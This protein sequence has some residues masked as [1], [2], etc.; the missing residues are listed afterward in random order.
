MQSS[1][2][3]YSPAVA[4]T[5]EIHLARQYSVDNLVERCLP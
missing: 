3:D 5:G 2:I 4:G 1:V